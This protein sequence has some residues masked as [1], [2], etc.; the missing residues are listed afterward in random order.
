MFSICS[1]SST[2]VSSA[3]SITLNS[4]L[5]SSCTA[6]LNG[7]SSSYLQDQAQVRFNLDRV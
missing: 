5:I 1:S 7:C 6:F 4:E 2:F 3:S